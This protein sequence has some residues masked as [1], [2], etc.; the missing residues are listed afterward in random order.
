MVILISLSLAYDL[1][2]IQTNLYN[3]SRLNTDVY[4]PKYIIQVYVFACKQSIGERFIK[5]VIYSSNCKVNSE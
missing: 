4:E 1:D 3:N 5:S 2:K